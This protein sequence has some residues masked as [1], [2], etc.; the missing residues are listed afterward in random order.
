[1]R[2]K[3]SGPYLTATWLWCY[4]GRVAGGSR[5]WE[6]QDDESPAAFARFLI[7]RD[8][9]ATERSLQK[10]ADHADLSKQLIARWSKRWSWPRRVIAYDNWLLELT[11]GLAKH[12]VLQHKR[13]LVRVGSASLDLASAALTKRKPDK[14]TISEINGLVS[15]GIRA[16]EQAFGP[17]NQGQAEPAGSPLVAINLNNNEVPGWLSESQAKVNKTVLVP[18]ENKVLVE[19][20]AALPQTGHARSRKRLTQ[21]QPETI[22][23]RQALKE[24]MIKAPVR[25]EE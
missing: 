18:I 3:V 7:Y 17:L 14:L 24:A 8:L 1:M 13:R 9:G 15:S 4:P 25:R 10:V 12:E 21:G 20:N 6:R 19:Q 5:P 16:G 23:K 11:D 2:H 22:V